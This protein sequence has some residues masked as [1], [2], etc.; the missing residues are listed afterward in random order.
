MPAP[1]IE[2]LVEFRDGSHLQMELP[3]LEFTLKAD[4]HQN[5]TT[6]TKILLA[7]TSQ[8]TFS[9]IPALKRVDRIRGAL[10]ALRDENFAIRESAALTLTKFGTGF[11]ELLQDKLDQAF[12]P[13]IRWRL[14]RVIEHLPLNASDEFD[15]VRLP[16]KSMRGEFEAWQATANYRDTVITLNRST[17]SSIRSPCRTNKAPPHLQSVRNTNSD[18]IPLACRKIDFEHDPGGKVLK[19]GE[20]IQ[21]TFIDWGLTFSS[22][23]KTSFVSVNRYDIEGAGGGKS[24]ATHDPLYEGAITIRFCVPGQPSR[25][26]GVGFIGCWLGIVKPGGTSMVAYDAYG[27]EIGR[28]VSSKGE[29]Q[30]LGVKSNVPIA[31]VEIVPN[32]EIDSNFALDDLIY[33]APIPLMD[34]LNPSH[35]SLLLRDGNLLN[36]QSVTP[37]ERAKTGNNNILARPGT[38]FASEISIP[39]SEISLLVPPS[40]KRHAPDPGKR[41]IWARLND[42]SQ[43]TL[44]SP[45]GKELKTF[46]GGFPA[47]KLKI[48]G[49][50]TSPRKLQYPSGKLKIPSGGAAIIIRNDPLY[51]TDFALGATQ[52]S[53]TRPDGSTVNYNYT[54]LPTIWMDNPSTLTDSI[55]RVELTDGQV[56]TFGKECFVGYC[57]LKADGIAMRINGDSRDLPGKTSAFNLNFHSVRSVHFQ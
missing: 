54:R 3:P 22:S 27:T 40:G 25:Q 10:Q 39:L 28:A 52:F 15:H 4:N 18:L 1:G 23:V 14:R 11:R 21:Q 6:R 33:D 45:E 7:E 16:N 13:E 17:V 49:L 19:A 26:S 44:L 34:A 46:L 55:G 2:R 56:I 42:G 38:P 57:T 51:L 5:R 24:A 29:S 48:T 12:D 41:K 31:R 50:W 47:E 36:C 43:L 32:P 35:F 8:I 37:P 20:N 9:E 30:F 53:G